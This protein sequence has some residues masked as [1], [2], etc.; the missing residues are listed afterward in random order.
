MISDGRITINISTDN[1][2]Y[3]ANCLNNE[4]VDNNMSDLLNKIFQ[5]S[6]EMNLLLDFGSKGKFTISQLLEMGEVTYYHFRDIPGNKKIMGTFKKNFNSI[7]DKDIKESVYSFIKTLA[8]YLKSVDFL[9]NPSIG[10]SQNISIYN[11]KGEHMLYLDV[12]NWKNNHVITI[13]PLLQF[14]QNRNKAAVNY[15]W[16]IIIE[17]LG[18]GGAED[19]KML[20]LGTDDFK[21]IDAYFASLNT[22]NLK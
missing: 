11:G 16:N 5:T 20:D 1:A 18:I 22:H 17:C 6:L 10:T 21:K 2:N 8:I 14:N 4:I 7:W 13:S 12:K 15:V 19:L 9:L 3:L